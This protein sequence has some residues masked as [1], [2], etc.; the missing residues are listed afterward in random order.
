M[1]K[2]IEPVTLASPKAAYTTQPPQVNV[3]EEGSRPRKK[4]RIIKKIVKKK[5]SDG[6]Y[7]T[8]ILTTTLK[9][10]GSKNMVREILRY[11]SHEH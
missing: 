1:I 7:I 11:D 4:K 6:T 8:E 10:D 9:R 2:K 5:C 3:N